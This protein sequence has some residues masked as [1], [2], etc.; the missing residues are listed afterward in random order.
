LKREPPRGWEEN[1]D[2]ALID[3]I[4]SNVLAQLQPE[5]PRP[6]VEAPKP[7]TETPKAP[8]PSAAVEITAAII[9]ADLLAESVRGGLPLRIGRK[10]ILTPSAR[11]WLN[12]KKI[13]WS[14]GGLVAEKP[15]AESATRGIA[16]WQL[17]VHTVT[18]NVRNLYEGLKRQAEGWKLELVGQA[19]EAATLAARAIS[20]AD[21]DGIVVLSEFAEIIS[22][23][24]NRNDRV[25]AAVVSDRK[26]LEMTRQHLGVNLVCINPNGR[27]FIELRNLLRDCMAMKPVPPANWNG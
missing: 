10:S 26:Q 1:V 11:D 8:V 13:S 17:I 21:Q 18:P 19:V 14:R 5:P 2:Q 4:V 25:R 23:R 15:A 3:R 7:A 12:T 27:T 22:C 6:V 24:A 20:T 9:T 16:R